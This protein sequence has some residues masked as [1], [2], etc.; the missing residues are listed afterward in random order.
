[1]IV[2]LNEARGMDAGVMRFTALR[3]VRMRTTL[4]RAN[5]ANY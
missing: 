4:T 2:N 5:P 1:M 3:A